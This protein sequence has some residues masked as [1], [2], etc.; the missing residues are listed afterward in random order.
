[1]Y[2]ASLISNIKQEVPQ[3]RQLEQ[4]TIITGS[5]GAG[6][7]S[8]IDAL[9]Y[10][11]TGKIDDL[12]LR[13]GVKDT[14]LLLTLAPPT[15]PDRIFASVKLDDGRKIHRELNRVDGTA[16]RDQPAEYPSSLAYLFE[17]ERHNDLIFPYR[18]IKDLLTSGTMGR[19]AA[20][21]RLASPETSSE[22]MADL[23]SLASSVELRIKESDDVSS[24]LD[25]ITLR[26]KDAKRK[27]KRAKKQAESELALNQKLSSS[28]ESVDTIES[29]IRRLDEVR[30]KLASDIESL[31]SKYKHLSHVK[32]L[33]ERHEEGF[34]KICGLFD[35][36]S[37]PDAD[38]CIHCGRHSDRYSNL[39]AKRS[40]LAVQMESLQVSLEYTTE[41]LNQLEDD[42]AQF[43]H[44][45][46]RY[47]QALNSLELAENRVNEKM[48]ELANRLTT[49]QSSQALN[50]RLRATIQEIPNRV[51]SI[52]LKLTKVK[53]LRNRLIDS[54]I[55][56]YT[57]EV[58]KFL[59][60]HLRF[61]VRV[62]SGK[63]GFMAGLEVGDH[64]RSSLSGAETAI[65]MVAMALAIP[66]SHPNPLRILALPDRDID[67][68]NFA[69]IL[70]PFTMST[71]Q[72]I[73][74]TTRKI[75]YDIPGWK[76]IR[77]PKKQTVV[78]DEPKV[79][80]SLDDVDCG[81]E[82]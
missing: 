59:P 42:F 72:I 3:E 4:F 61:G 71:C 13:D 46:T 37:L 6:K 38:T 44:P 51:A 19:R 24:V 15:E 63:V 64:V 60:S 56:K 55:D 34:R 29:E 33:K 12:S 79:F 69:A 41:L 36:I 18:L 70:H 54:V 26:L 50:Q 81:G 7:T 1:M 45:H 76:I 40:D 10:C 30:Q 5:N 68:E 8:V 48:T 67:D 74:T 31:D 11:L 73:I 47:D 57:T 43:I 53:E 39:L 80:S 32:G 66:S 21:F 27:L 22:D 75:D 77:L 49:L 9:Q 35:E 52:N 78:Y 20:F 17:D 23:K 28:D 58:N 65:L 82:E 16:R 2:V 62:G 14:S 25:E